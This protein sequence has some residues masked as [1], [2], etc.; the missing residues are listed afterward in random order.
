MAYLLKSYGHEE[1]LHYDREMR[2]IGTAIIGAVIAIVIAIVGVL[3]SVSPVRAP[4]MHLRVTT[5]TTPVDVNPFTSA[6]LAGYLRGRVNLVTAAVYDVTSG[7]TYLYN[8]GVHEVTASMVKIDILAALLH[9]VQGEHRGLSAME[10]LLASK[11][12]IGSNNRD[13]T[14]LWNEVGQLPAMTAFH[15]VVGYHQTIMSWSWGEIETTPLDELALLKVITLPNA[16]LTDASRAYEE[17]LMQSPGLSERFGLGDGPPATATIGLKDGYFP[18]KKTGWQINSAGYVRFSSRFYLAAIMTADN[19]NETY[20]INTVD[21]V[22]EMIWGSL[23][24]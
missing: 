19:P 20:G 4:V 22:A 18:E 21:S 16:I 15:Q 10:S 3:S 8:P 23:R 5:T 1:L 17:S 9:E 14:K 7:K 6:P 12:V 13:A 2:V 24:P 11:M